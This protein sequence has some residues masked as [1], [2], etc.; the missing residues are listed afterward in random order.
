M[1]LTNENSVLLE[2]RGCS[3]TVACTFDPFCV[4]S[5]SW[6]NDGRKILYSRVSALTRR[7]MYY[8][9][10]TVDQLTDISTFNLP[11]MFDR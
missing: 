5:P 2:C 4:N 1:N 9:M 6:F 11:K 7:R 3:Y 10:M 8:L